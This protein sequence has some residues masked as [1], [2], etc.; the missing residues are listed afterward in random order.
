MSE[1]PK[2][3]PGA[4][5]NVGWLVLVATEAVRF[6]SVQHHSEIL[7]EIG[8]ADLSSEAKYHAKVSLAGLPAQPCN[9]T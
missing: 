3:V 7:D 9:T 6:F 2:V 4:P 5:V 1:Q 8:K